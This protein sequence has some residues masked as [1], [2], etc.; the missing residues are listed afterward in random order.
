[1]AEKIQE[2]ISD[3]RSRINDEKIFFHPHIP[4]KKLENAISVYGSSADVNDVLALIDN[5]SFGNAKDGLLLTRSALYVHNMLE[6]PFYIALDEISDV[7]FKSGMLES[8]LIINEI[9]IFKSNM[10]KKRNTALFAEMLSTLVDVVGVN[11]LKGSAGHGVKE[12]L[13][14]L[15]DLFDEGLLTEAEYAQKRQILVAKI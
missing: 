6:T 10:P 15:K 4:L 11:A 12:A 8:A 7:R 2:L 5:T 13:R 9:Y 1:M 3:Y 14:E